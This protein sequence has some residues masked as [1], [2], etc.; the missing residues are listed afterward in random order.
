MTVP[1][2]S[3]REESSYEER[4]NYT[5]VP[6][7]V[8]TVH[9]AQE[10]AKEQR[11]Q[12]SYEAEDVLPLPASKYRYSKWHELEDMDIKGNMLRSPRVRR[13]PRGFKLENMRK[14]DEEEKLEYGDSDDDEFRI[15][16]PLKKNK[17]KRVRNYK[18]K[19]ENWENAESA[20]LSYQD[21]GDPYQ[22]KEFQRVLRR[23]IRCENLQL[24]ENSIQ[25]LSTVLLPR[26][27]HLYL[28]RNFITDLRKLPRAPLLEHLSLQQNNVESLKGLEVL[29]KTGIQSL[30][31][32]GNPIELDPNYRQH[33]FRILPNLQLLDG[34]PR[35]DSDS[36]D[37]VLDS[38]TCI[39]S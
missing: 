35:L 22:K 3:D 31:L 16:L 10:E 23:L 29:R 26:C 30:V 2:M 33:V 11:S 15:S 12:A 25:D 39:V 38:K 27:T 9:R 13:N 4:E 6:I 14:L 37:A 32:K 36:A 17:P 5:S 19:M 28:Q 7:V 24:I 34:I 1:I 20:N 21:L 18:N 8:L